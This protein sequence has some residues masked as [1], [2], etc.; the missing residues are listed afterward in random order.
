MMRKRNVRA[1]FYWSRLSYAPAMGSGFAG[2]YGNF[3]GY[4]W[5]H[6]WSRDYPKADRQ[7][8]LAMK[9]LT[10]DPDPLHRAGGEPRF[11]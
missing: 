4:G 1:E 8:L 5:H 7:V 3:G 9:R 11:G 2:G 6:S 10:R